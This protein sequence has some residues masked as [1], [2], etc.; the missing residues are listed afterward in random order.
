LFTQTSRHSFI[1]SLLKIPH[2]I[3]CVN[4]MDLVDYSQEAFDKIVDQYSTFASKLEVKDIRFIPISALEGD[5]VVN[6]S[7]KT[8]WYEGATLLHELETMHIGSDQN[9]IDCRFAVQTVIRPHSEDHHDFRGYAG[10]IQGGVYKPGDEVIVLPSGYLSKIKNIYDYDNEV[11][12]AF[13]PMSVTITLEDDIDVS[14]GDMI[15]RRNNQP[16]VGQEIEVMVCWMHEQSPR[17]RA[18]YIIRQTTNEAKAII[19]DI[20]YK[21]DINTLHRLEED[22]KINMNDIFRAHIRVT[23]PIL[24]DSYKQNRNTGS[25][26]LVDEFTNETV[27]A[28]MII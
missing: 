24:F 19:R 17:P 28:G 14:R 3:V 7:E 11:E 10:R 12:E 16:A 18:K 26:I 2:L 4:K 9:H 15:V 6:R 8:P 27:A 23:K 21:V 1:A 20:K 13:S 25:I 5:N 22:K